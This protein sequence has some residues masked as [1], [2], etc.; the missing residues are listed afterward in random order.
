VVLFF[1]APTLA[2]QPIGTERP[3][4][5]P[6]ISIPG[7]KPTDL[8]DGVTTLEAFKVQSEVLKNSAKDLE[9]RKET[10]RVAIDVITAD[11]ISKFDAS[12]VAEV[13]IRIPGVSVAGGQFAVIRGLSDRFLSTTLNGLK[14]PS[15]DPEKQAFQLDLI[16]TSAVEAVIVSKAFEASLWADSTGG[17]MDILTRTIPS[18]RFTKVGVGLKAN[19]NA[20]SGYLDYPA[21]SGWLRERFGFGSK[22]RL[23]VGEMDGNWQYVPL[24]KTD[25]PIGSSFSLEHGNMFSLPGDLRLGVLLSIANSSSVEAEEGRHDVRVSRRGRP[26]I[27]ARNLPPVFSDFETSQPRPEQYNQHVD[28]SSTTTEYSSSVSLGLGLELSPDH[29]LKFGGLWVQSGTDQAYVS[30]TVTVADPTTGER[31]LE[32]PVGPP[33]DNFDAVYSF[34]NANEYFRERDLLSL[35]L[36]GSHRSQSRGL[37]EVAWAIQRSKASQKDH[38]F[39]EAQF[40]TLLS[41]YRRSYIPLGGNDAPT[42]LVVAWAS[43]EEIQSAGRL[44]LRWP[45]EIGRDRTIEISAGGALERSGREVEGT[46]IFYDKPDKSEVFV[47][48]SPVAAVAQSAREPDFTFSSGTRAEREI[49]AFYLNLEVPIHRTLSLVAGARFED[50]LLDARGL[51]KWGVYSTAILYDPSPGGGHFGRFLGTTP[52]GESIFQ[53]RNWYPGYA[54]RWT[55]VEAITVRLSHS[56]TDGRPSFRE[57]SPYFNKSISTGNLVV[58]NPVLR[59]SNAENWDARVEWRPNSNT[60]LSG[61]YFRKRIEQPIEKFVLDTRSV[62]SFYTEVWV[63]N[64]GRA[65]IEGYEIEARQEL[66]R[67]SEALAGWSAGFNFTSIDAQVPEHPTSLQAARPFFGDPLNLPT[68]RRLFDQPERIANFD[69]TWTGHSSGTRI[70]L[71]AY[72]VSDTLAAAGLQSFAF[73]LYERGYIAYDLL[74]SQSLSSTTK[75]KVAIRNLSDPVRGTIYDRDATYGLV[76]SREYRAG[77][78]FGFSVDSQF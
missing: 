8:Q 36:A 28:Y 53:S 58:G 6:T 74:F 37:P 54:V 72:G 21:R 38:P 59:P 9:R 49:N 73:D 3:I 55:P 77:R 75:L 34:F 45:V 40:S 71:A 78:E 2:S 48:D 32:I 5:P 19:S 10:S 7:S 15:P 18:E 35:Q 39:A 46:G 65:D 76:T 26:A 17:A 24:R 67:L 52:A 47:V 25:K 42:P 50:F 66:A 57:V 60:Y 63:N 4:L 1:L 16:P 11:Q 31:K 64:P 41:D 61:S 44:D 68:S 14:L 20:M 12:D 13:V 22:I 23:S 29:E 43:N 69:I 33:L 51:G 27:A 62:A 30:E 56:E 70:T